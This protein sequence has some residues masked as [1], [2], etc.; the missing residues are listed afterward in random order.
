MGRGLVPFNHLSPEQTDQMNPS[1]LLILV[2]GY[3]LSPELSRVFRHFL[4]WGR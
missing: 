4:Q 1:T 2:E 3:H